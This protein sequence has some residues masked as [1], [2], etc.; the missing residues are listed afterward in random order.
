MKIPFLIVYA[1][2]SLMALANIYASIFIHM[3]YDA[4]YIDV[5]HYGV[6]IIVCSILLI[7]ACL[8]L[9]FRT[10]CC[11]TPTT[12]ILVVQLMAVLLQ[13]AIACIFLGALEFLAP[14]SPIYSQSTHKAM[15]K[16]CIKTKSAST[17][18]H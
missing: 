8:F 13:F 9:A 3:I 7:P 18:I 12:I 10:C 17:E 2:S 6:V 11:Q 5:W 4:Y 14:G 16:P 15:K 1:L